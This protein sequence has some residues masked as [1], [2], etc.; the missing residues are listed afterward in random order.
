MICLWKCNL[1][2]T[3]RSSASHVPVHEEESSR[4]PEECASSLQR[5]GWPQ[6]T[7]DQSSKR[8]K[9]KTEAVRKSFSTE[10]LVFTT[11]M[12][13]WESGNVAASNLLHEAAET[14]PK[15]AAKISLAWK[16]EKKLQG[17]KKCILMRKRFPF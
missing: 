6:E 5:Q 16:K 4:H 3:K 13:L 15:R 7:F 10:E 2:W 12:R 8:T 14:T 9:R 1:A 11:Q 17:K